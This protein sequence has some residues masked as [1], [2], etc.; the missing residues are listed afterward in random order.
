MTQEFRRIKLTPVIDDLAAREAFN[1]DAV[2]RHR[3]TCRRHT[4]KDV[5]IISSLCLGERDEI[6]R[7]QETSEGNLGVKRG[8]E[9]FRA[10]FESL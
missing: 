9:H 6:V 8:A 2:H 1:V 10:L 4:G 5:L 3:F 7:C